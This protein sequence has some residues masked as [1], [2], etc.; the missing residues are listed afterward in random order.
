MNGTI[1]INEDDIYEWMFLDPL[2]DPK[3]SIHK[4]HQCHH[5]NFKMQS[6]SGTQPNSTLL[7][8]RKD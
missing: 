5:G 4:C 3:T 7:K 8:N 2:A 1:T 6:F